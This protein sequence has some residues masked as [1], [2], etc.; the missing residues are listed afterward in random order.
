MAVGGSLAAFAAAPVL[1][2]DNEAAIEALIAESA[3]PADAMAA[4]RAQTAAGDLTGAAATLERA[5]LADPNANDARLLYAATL[6]RMGDLQAAQIE[7]GKL[8]RQDYS[9]A[10][11][12]EAQQ[13]C[14]GAVRKPVAADG[15][16]SDGISGEIYA[17]LA[18][19]GDAAGA[20]A[21]Q[22]DFG[23][24]GPDREEGLAAIAGARL[25][26]RSEDYGT[27]GGFYGGLSVISK[28][29]L[30][31]PDQ[32]YDIGQLRAGY[33]RSGGRTGFAIGVVAAHTRLFGDPYVTEYGGQGELTFGH[34]G[35]RRV[36]LRAEAVAQDYDEGF[37]GDG[38]DGMRFDLSGALELR[39]GAKGLFT[40]GVG[41]ELK[42]ADT[43]SLGYHGGRLFAAAQVALPR[44]HY[45]GL[46]GTLRYIDFRDDEP[47]TDRKDLRAYARAAYGIPIG[48]NGLFAEGAG[49]YTLRSVSLSSTTGGSVPDLATYRSPGADLRLIWKF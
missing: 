12:A 17:G 19:D 48:S 8:D 27:S 22:T 41:G 39:I 37:P 21:L 32:D 18:Y 45:F 35:T 34:A 9:G 29:D 38:A 14:G 26:L 33:G 40:A 42:T 28:H 44:R 2:Q 10:I 13:A 15:E 49:T 7:I 43:R 30:S 47:F 24:D 23:F 5:L 11:W 20:I 3:S 1:A 46:S 36:R 16:A 25:L 6:C 31:G 4:A